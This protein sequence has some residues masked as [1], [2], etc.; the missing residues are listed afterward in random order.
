VAARAERKYVIFSD[1]DG[2]LLDHDNYSWKAARPA[3]EII[4]DKKIP[5][6]LC[7]SKTRAEIE[8]VR[9]KLQ[10]QDPF[11]SENGGGIFIPKD[12]FAFGFPHRKRMSDYKVIELGT[13][14]SF[15]R[16]SLMSITEETGVTLKGF[17]DW[18]A[19][20]ISRQTGLSVKEARLAKKREYDEPFV[21]L[22][23]EQ[24][25]QQILGVIAKM[26][27]CWTRGGRYYHLTGHNDKGKALKLLSGLFERKLG[28]IMTVAIGDNAND[29]PMLEVA[30]YSILV[31]KP[32]GL[33][34]VS[35]H[36]ANLHRVKGIGP[37]G[38]RNGIMKLLGADA[39]S[40]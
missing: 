20:E 18:T 14:Y 37:E 35:G 36:L 9:R 23:P 7:S 21:L 33:Y 22:G 8:S 17:G 31:Q 13:A 34:E 15:L 27:L 2:T 10:N 6:I 4:H 40:K 11:I 39:Q 32:D 1:L 12:Y 24:Q 16:K 28:K 3:L 19:A 29:L 30:D 25:R 5:L 26:G 38:W